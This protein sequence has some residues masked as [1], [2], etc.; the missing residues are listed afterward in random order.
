MEG[1]EK[2]GLERVE[3]E[4]V[5]LSKPNQRNIYMYF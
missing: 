2:E 4:G 3:P 5:I 1:L